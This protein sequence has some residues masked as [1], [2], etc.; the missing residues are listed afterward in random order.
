MEE[1]FAL[2]E[3]VKAKANAQAGVWASFFGS[4]MS[5]TLLTMLRS[6]EG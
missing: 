2:V 6:T 5:L 1:R 4:Q 3:R